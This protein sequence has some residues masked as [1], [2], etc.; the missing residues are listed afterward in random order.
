MRCR[1]VLVLITW[2]IS[3][4]M[5]PLSAQED[6]LR[7]GFTGPLTG[8]N[9]FLGKQMS[10]GIRLGF[11]RLNDSNTLAY[12]VSIAALDDG[13]EPEQTAPL[14]NELVSLY[15]V[16]GLLGSV[17]TPTAVTSLPLLK[18]YNIPL[19]APLT[20]ARILSSVHAK[21][22]VFNL[23]ANYEEEAFKL[24]QTLIN[25]FHIKPKEVAILIQKDSFGEGALKGLIRALK[26]YGL[27]DANSILQIRYL[28]NHSAAENAAAQ[29]LASPH[30]PKVVFLIGTYSTSA[31]LINLLD[32]VGVTPLYA[33]FS[34]VGLEPLVERVK[35]SNAAIL[36]SQIT[37]PILASEL[38]IV[39]EF[40]ADHAQYGDQQLTTSLEL[41]GYIA[42]RLIEYTLQKYSPNTPPTSRQLMSYLE[43]LTSFDLGLKNP[44]FFSKHAHQATHDIWLQTIYQDKV[45]PYLPGSK[46]TDTFIKINQGDSHG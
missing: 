17:G 28:R 9:A 26:H 3:A 4:A 32:D 10:R 34:F 37:P 11:A 5:V 46:T 44:L 27:K 13:Y 38:P 42:A 18:Q 31:A 7:F 14:I 23:R 36:A 24:V 41:E 33:A 2:L 43:S 19:I 8:P 16:V 40:L 45:T 25:D 30:D 21:P 22:Y 12:T 15:K 20:G 35:G 39:K 29:I 6:E 1:H